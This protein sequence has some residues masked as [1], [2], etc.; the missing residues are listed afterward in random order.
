MG[1]GADGLG[2]SH[3]SLKSCVEQ[4]V[5]A[6]D[7]LLRTLALNIHQHPELSFQ[8]HQAMQWLVEPLAEAGF[9]IET[10]IAGLE[11][12][13]RATWG[14]SDGPVIALLAEYDALPEIGHACGHNLI[15]TAAVG[16]ALAL[17][18]ACPD[19]PARIAVIGT[20]AEED[21][22]GKIIMCNAGV[23]DDVDAAMLCHPRNIT[24][25]NRGSLAC[26][27]ATFKFY[28]RQAHA[29]SAPEEGISALDAVIQSFVAIN[30]LRQFFKS[31]VKIHGIITKGGSAPNVVPEFCEAKF[32]LRAIT[33]EELAAV[34]EKVYAAVRHSADAVGARCEIEEGLIY[35]ERNNNRA[36]AALF[37]ENLVSLGL[38][39]SD[40]P[41]R[42]G[43]GSS[44]I[45][46]VGQV[47]A[48]IHPYIRI[49][50]VSNH[51]PAFRDA[52]ASEAGLTAL[53]QAAKALA[54][55]AYDLAVNPQALQAVREEFEQWR[56][57]KASYA[58][59]S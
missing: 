55:T 27:D 24:T 57:N 12:A 35:A 18:D 52:A 50:D 56:A 15:G 46:N 1:E 58:H 44:D 48:T 33:V 14:P 32:I 11:T 6:R 41:A 5:D 13:F 40:P 3:I 7:A 47:T 22:G 34:R 25:V 8:E 29:S 9:E 37:K 39:V 53:N 10:G 21:G 4:A 26:V 16:A 28:G 59:T 38:E 43:L 31:D 23:F 20:P 36:L 17:R 54:M 49:G 45:G 19:L 30:A 2:E 42:A 51:T